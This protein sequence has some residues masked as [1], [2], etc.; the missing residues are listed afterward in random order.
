MQSL[1]NKMK[2]KDKMWIPSYTKCS[3]DQWSSPTKN[4]KITGYDVTKIDLILPGV[5]ST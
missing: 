2:T 3:F 4:D 1:L 5:D